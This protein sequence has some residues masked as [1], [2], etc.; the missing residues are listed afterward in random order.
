MKS[1]EKWLN[2]RSVIFGS[3][4]PSNRCIEAR[5]APS[6]SSMLP[7]VCRRSWKRM[8]RTRALGQGFMP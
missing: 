7:E 6:M 8:C 1:G 2:R 5:F 4:W 3:L